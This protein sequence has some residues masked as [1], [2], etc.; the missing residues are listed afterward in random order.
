MSNNGNFKE[1]YVLYLTQLVFAHV[2]T[3]MNGS[4]STRSVKVRLGKVS[5]WRQVSTDENKR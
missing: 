1:L 4:V 5:Y 3:Q 2:E